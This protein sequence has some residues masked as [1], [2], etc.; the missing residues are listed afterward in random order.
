VLVQQLG[1]PI[2]AT[3]L[4]LLAGAHAATD[5]IHGVYVL[6]LAIAA[7]TLGSLPWYWAK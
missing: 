4:L 1:A 7:S 2:P 6:A 3:P 5:P